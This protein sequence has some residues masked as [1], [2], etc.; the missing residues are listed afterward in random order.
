VGADALT[1]RHLAA[2]G[3][4]AG[5]VVALVRNLG[6]DG[7]VVGLAEDRLALPRDLA[8]AI[9]VEDAPAPAPAAAGRELEVEA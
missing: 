3:L 5:T 8:A 7:V 6:A 2:L 1:N 9:G 4:R